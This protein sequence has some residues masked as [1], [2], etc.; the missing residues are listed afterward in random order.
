[1]AM[2]VV[3]LNQTSGLGNFMGGVGAGISR[4]TEMGMRKF[5]QDR[6]LKQQL[7]LGMS[8]GSID[9]RILLTDAGQSFLHQTGLLGDPDLELTLNNA[10]KSML[11]PAPP[12]NVETEVMRPQMPPTPAPAAPPTVGPP[13]PSPAL[14]ALGGY[15]ANMPQAE[16]QA[17]IDA[18]FQTPPSTKSVQDILEIEKGQ[19]MAAMED[20]RRAVDSFYHQ[21]DLQKAED[22]RLQRMRSIPEQAA[23]EQELMK[24][25]PGLNT[26]GASFDIDPNGGLIWHF[27]MPDPT[28]KAG[29]E[30]KTSAR[31]DKVYALINHGQATRTQLVG[32]VQNLLSGDL[33]AVQSAV[34]SGLD[35]ET[36]ANLAKVGQLLSKTQT[37]EKALE[38][39]SA[40]QRVIDQ[41]NE[42]IKSLN[43][44]IASAVDS[45]TDVETG[46]QIFP[47]GYFFDHA[48]VHPITFNDVSGG[49]SPEQY[50]ERK[51]TSSTKKLVSDLREPAAG[52]PPYAGPS[53]AAGTSAT[54]KVTA[55]FNDLKATAQDAWTKNPGLTAVK[56]RQAVMDHKDQLMAEYGL[57]E[58][59]FALVLKMGESV[60]G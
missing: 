25:I 52:A 51:A 32:H 50:I 47:S 31:T 45:A 40:A 39:V 36:A 19:K 7:L 55:A 18:A 20:Q 35:P 16:G 54:E 34:R 9:P 33:A 14:T 46:E 24:H 59:L 5:E 58:H 57:N 29:L 4:G 43:A 1:M 53:A 17:R 6:Q 3:E 56:L 48:M 22:M 38:S 21:R 28:K 15:A 41:V 37:K 10:R 11:G 12:A 13:A 26:E 23:I 60:L 49:L 44:S 8:N 2:P 42:Q 30:D 27:K